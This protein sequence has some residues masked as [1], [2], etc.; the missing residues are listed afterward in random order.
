MDPNI[1]VGLLAVGVVLYVV[2][3]V[4][5]VRPSGGV[6]KSVKA[7]DVSGQVVVADR[8]EGGVTRCRRRPARSSATSPASW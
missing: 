3:L 4:V 1:G 8:V 6:G 5:L 2:L 7:R